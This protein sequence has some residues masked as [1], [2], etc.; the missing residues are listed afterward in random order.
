MHVHFKFMLLSAFAAA[1]EGTFKNTSS[2]YTIS[3]MYIFDIGYECHFILA[4]INVQLMLLFLRFFI[5]LS[6][7]S[8]L[9][10]YNVVL[11][12]KNRI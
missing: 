6:V 4:E 5:V 8:L 1:K 3:N 11:L 9:F 10:F 7:K 2:S 12:K